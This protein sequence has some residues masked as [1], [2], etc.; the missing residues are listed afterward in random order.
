M[1]YS[2]D[3]LCQSPG[4]MKNSSYHTATAGIRTSDLSHSMIM[5]KKDL[6]SYPLGQPQ[7][8]ATDRLYTTRDRIWSIFRF[9][10]SNIYTCCTKTRCRVHQFSLDSGHTLGHKTEG[11]LP[12][13]VSHKSRYWCRRITTI[14]MVQ[15][16]NI[17]LK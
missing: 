5:N 14:C 6:R 2:A 1:A 12:M 17:F 7:R 8:H 4:W 13:D 11:R 16:V 3:K 9:L 10:E 15:C